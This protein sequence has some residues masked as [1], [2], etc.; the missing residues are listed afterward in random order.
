MKY[1]LSEKA[2][3]DIKGIYHYTH[4]QFGEDQA[5]QYHKGIEG[6]FSLIVE[7]P[8]LGKERQDVDNSTRSFLHQSHIIYYELRDDY[9][10]ILRVLH[11]QQ[12]PMRHL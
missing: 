9:I 2:T 6:A 11:A 1:K 12:D 5:V 7:H 3:A 4:N 10:F 8:Q